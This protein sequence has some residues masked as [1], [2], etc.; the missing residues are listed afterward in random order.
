MM[1]QDRA[2][3]D[4]MRSTVDTSPMV[5]YS[6]ET[7]RQQTAARNQA[8]NRNRRMLSQ[9]EVS[10]F[11]ESR[12]QAL[13]KRVRIEGALTKDRIP[14]YLFRFANAC[15]Q[16]TGEREPDVQR[17]VVKEFTET[18]SGILMDISNDV[19]LSS[20]K[21]AEYRR[22]IEE[23]VGRLNTD[24]IGKRFEIVQDIGV[25]LAEA[26]I[27][28]E[29][30]LSIK[31]LTLPPQKMLSKA[32]ILTICKQKIVP[33]GIDSQA[34][35]ITVGEY[36]TFPFNA[37]P[38]DDDNWF[39]IHLKYLKE[40]FKQ[41][42]ISSAEH[43]LILSVVPYLPKVKYRK[44]FNMFP[45]GKYQDSITMAALSLFQ[46]MAFGKMRIHS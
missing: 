7:E 18:V 29:R 32:E 11:I 20:S 35:K 28:S 3:K 46:N 34:T 31:D 38:P 9:S 25:T 40:L 41:D 39:A 42:R 19:Q 33:I 8:A 5:L 4:R 30:K 16:V 45:G 12:L 26:A 43:S 6:K 36:F 10:K 21:T 14:K 13:Y 2:R 27:R 15:G 37:S 44:Y 17:K 23:K 24:N 1:Q 22:E